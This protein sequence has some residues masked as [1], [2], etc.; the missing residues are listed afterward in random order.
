[1][2]KTFIFLA[3]CALVFLPLF[4]AEAAPATSTATSSTTTISLPNPL[5]SNTFEELITTIINWLL[6]ITGPIVALLIVFAGARIAFSGGS[7][8][9][10][11]GA[12]DMIVYSLIGYTVIII[13]K[14]LVAVVKGLFG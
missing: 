12:R 7:A 14:V 5:T 13:A 8:E 4:F 10:V 9:Q 1:M 3:V 6:V 2:R 11:K